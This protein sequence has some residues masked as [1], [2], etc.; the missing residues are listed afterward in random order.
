MCLLIFIVAKPLSA[1]VDSGFIKCSFK[2]NNFIRSIDSLNLDTEILNKR[3]IEEEQK[4]TECIQNF[5]VPNFNAITLNNDSFC[6][7][8]IN[9]KVIVMNFWSL[10]CPPCLAELGIFSELNQEYNNKD[11]LFISICIDR[12][13]KFKNRPIPK[14]LTIVDASEILSLYGITSYPQT[15]IVTK[16][17]KLKKVFGGASLIN[18]DKLKKNI[19]FQINEALKE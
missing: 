4:W 12:K 16:S 5:Q 8:K 3:F 19:S 14:I 13:S 2:F 7:S 1:Q 11:V 10:N 17:H 18:N 15:F 6:L 9:N